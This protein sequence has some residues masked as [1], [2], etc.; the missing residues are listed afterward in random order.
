MDNE[1]S[2]KDKVTVSATGTKGTGVNKKT[3]QGTKKS[4]GNK[5]G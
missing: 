5:K 1:N 3:K 2:G 4:K